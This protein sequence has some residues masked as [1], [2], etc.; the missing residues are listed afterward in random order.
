MAAVCFTVAFF[1][2]LAAY[3]AY[4]AV[5]FMLTVVFH[6]ADTGLAVSAASVKPIMLLHIAEQAAAAGIVPFM[7]AI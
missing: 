1:Y 6:L 7:A 3:I 4:T 2:F 5:K